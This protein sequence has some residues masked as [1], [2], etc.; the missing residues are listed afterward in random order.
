MLR[1]ME[2][3]A[4]ELKLAF[5]T[6]QTVFEGFETKSTEDSLRWVGL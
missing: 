5:V 6:V 1:M 3:F 4:D 2:L